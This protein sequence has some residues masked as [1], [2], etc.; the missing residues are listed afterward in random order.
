MVEGILYLFEINML[1]DM[2]YYQPAI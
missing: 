2:F 1:N